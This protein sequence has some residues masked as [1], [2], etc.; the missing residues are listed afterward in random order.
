VVAIYRDLAPHIL[1]FTAMALP[2]GEAGRH[3][4]AVAMRLRTGVLAL[5]NVVFASAR[6]FADRFFHTEEA[7]GVCLPWAFHLDFAPDVR[8]GAAFAFISTVS[9]HLNGLVV[10]AGGAEAI[11]SALR[12]LIE[13]HGGTIRRAKFRKCWSRTGV[14]SGSEPRRET[15]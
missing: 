10:A 13:Q 6:Q 12:A 5:R 2:S 14:R 7:K 3:A 11:V 1:P 8:G 15:S 9:A 4:L